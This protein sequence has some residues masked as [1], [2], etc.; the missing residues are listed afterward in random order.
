MKIHEIFGKSIIYVVFGTVVSIMIAYT[1][2]AI[3]ISDRLS[4][5]IVL[6][7]ERAGQAWYINPVDKRRYYM[8]RPKDA[9]SLMRELGLGISNDNLAKIPIAN[10]G[11]KSIDV[12]LAN[13]LKG[14]ILL[15]VEDKGQAWYVNP[16]DGNRYYL[17]R[18]KDAFSIMRNFGLGIT[19]DDISLISVARGEPVE[20]N[21]QDAD[22]NLKQIG[23]Q[24]VS[25]SGPLKIDG[26]APM[27][28]YLTNTGIFLET[29]M[30]RVANGLPEFRYSDKLSKMAQKKVD[31]MIASGY[32][33]HV[34]PDGIGIEDLALD[35]GYDYI[36]IG[37]NLALGNVF[38]DSSLLEGW[39]NSPGH[40]ANILND[41]FS[42]LGV[43]SAQG[44]YNGTT[45]WFAVQEFGKPISDCPVVDDTL[46]DK[47]S[48]EQKSIDK[49]SDIISQ[50]RKRLDDYAPLDTGNPEEVS[51]YNSDV[52]TYNSL[53]NTFN[54]QLEY[55]KNLIDEYNSQV[56][57][58]TECAE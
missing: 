42:E 58:Y 55:L 44:E 14:R 23:N 52:A 10:Q 35:V 13:R 53:V 18:P 6:Q 9:F 41:K 31:D 43:A 50:Q 12:N 30:R 57:A 37:G 21:L 17:G 33:A 25:L 38:T 19:D 5:R 45:V 2:F 16:V 11:A 8:G 3:D 51:S 20:L 32:F 46:N 1:A 48:V 15:Q 49:L 26:S 22:F 4:G 29:N 24:E 56:I 47:I 28:S 34:S 27:D 7:V 39:M 40:R 36:S 54:S